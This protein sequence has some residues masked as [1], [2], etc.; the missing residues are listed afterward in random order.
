MPDD[1]R[2]LGIWTDVFLKQV[3]R[4]MWKVAETRDA[5]FTVT[6]RSG[7][8]RADIGSAPFVKTADDQTHK[9]FITT[10]PST[11]QPPPMAAMNGVL[12]SGSIM[13]QEPQS[14]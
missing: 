8:K 3:V 9:R 13:T 14:G 7:L 11:I 12:G 10:R 5:T 2:G 6:G 1:P 4:L